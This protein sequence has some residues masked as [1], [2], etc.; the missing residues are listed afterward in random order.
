MKKGKMGWSQTRCCVLVCEYCGANSVSRFVLHWRSDHRS[1]EPFS[2]RDA[3]CESSSCYEKYVE[4]GAIQSRSQIYPLLPNVLASSEFSRLRSQIVSIFKT[5][6][7]LE[8]RVTEKIIREL[9][10]RISELTGE[11]EHRWNNHYEFGVPVKFRL[12][13]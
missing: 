13:S 7:G 6:L 10:G 12:G 11:E 8:A 1:F 5:L 9:Y 4:S 3:F 2:V